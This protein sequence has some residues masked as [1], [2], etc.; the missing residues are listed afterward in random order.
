MIGMVHRC[1]FWG[2]RK[3][4]LHKW[5]RKWRKTANFQCFYCSRHNWA[6]LHWRGPRLVSKWPVWYADVPIGVSSTTIVL[7]YIVVVV[8]ILGH[9]VIS[10][11]F[12]ITFERVEQIECGLLQL[13]RAHRDAH[14]AFLIVTVAQTS[15]EKHWFI[16]FKNGGLYEWRPHGRNICLSFLKF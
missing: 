8:F 11:N 14:F 4:H 15:R 1:A 2:F 9:L 13:C 12:A 16:T 3:S 10:R 7:L 5:W 6:I